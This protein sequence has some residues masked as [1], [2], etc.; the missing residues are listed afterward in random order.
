MKIFKIVLV[1]FF[2]PTFAYSI[3]P[4][5]DVFEIHPLAADGATLKLV[6]QNRGT[7]ERIYDLIVKV[8][9]DN[10]CT[11]PDR[12]VKRKRDTAFGLNYHLYAFSYIDR[13][14]PTHWMPIEKDVIID[15]VIVPEGQSIPNISING[16]PVR[17]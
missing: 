5:S 9:S 2:I 11:V 13:Q 4:R 8:N 17:T 16:K 12:F 6:E 1:L 3:A 10:S 7:G 14:C 15:S